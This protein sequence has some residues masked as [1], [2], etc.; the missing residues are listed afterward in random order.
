MSRYMRTYPRHGCVVVEL[1]GDIDVE[2]ADII[3][4]ALDALTDRPGPDLVLDLGPVDFLDCSGLSVLCRVR[5]RAT[6]HDRKLHLVCDHPMTLR[7][8]RATG[9]IAAFR[10]VPTLDQALAGYE[11]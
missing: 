3:T 8:M 4:P 10:P 5:R 1:S 6:R 11:S 2:A 7:I 9:L